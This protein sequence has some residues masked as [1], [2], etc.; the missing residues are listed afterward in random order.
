MNSKLIANKINRR[1]R[2]LILAYACEPGAGSEPGTGWNMARHLAE[3]HEVTV[4]TRANNKD[5]INAATG[6]PDCLHFEFI[7]PPTW[8]Y[9]LK[10]R[11]IIPT[12]LFYLF[13]QMAVSSYIKKSHKKYDIA[14]QLTFNSFETPPLC[15]FHMDAAK[16]WGPVGGG[17]ICYSGLFGYLGP[18]GFVKEFLRNLR[19]ACSTYNPIT[20]RIVELCSMVLFANN[21]TRERLDPHC[22]KSKYRM[23]DVGVDMERFEPALQRS[24]NRPITFLAVGKLLPRKGCALMIRSFSAFSIKHPDAILK[25]VGEGSD[26]KRLVKM[27]EKH[28]LEGKV[29]FLGGFDHEE[30]VRIYTDA[31]VFLFPSIR[32]TSGSVILEAMS[33]EL[34][35]IC[36][37]HQGV[38]QIIDDYSGIRIPVNGNAEIIS[39]MAEAMCLLASN[40][41][42]RERMGRQGRAEVRA[43][44]DWKSKAAL[45][46]N[47]YWEVINESSTHLQDKNMAANT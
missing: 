14:H 15:F 7:D 18:L 25:V 24:N 36:L 42:M 47:L 9:P 26:R 29:K 37:N 17:Q 35:V 19:V 12:Q 40:P 34:P 30:M 4:I 5:A 38:A 31:D 21:E 3:H 32:D 44:Y 1:L 11:G 43:K 33:M 28:G 39:S 41:S 2:V 8:L 13:W 22:R 27:I 23:I 6:T 46:S 16:I 45:I 10:K 20:R